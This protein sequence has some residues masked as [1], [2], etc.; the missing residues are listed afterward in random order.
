VA[1]HTAASGALAAHPSEESALLQ[2]HAVALTS[3]DR[4][5]EAITVLRH[6][7]H[8]SPLDHRAALRLGSALEAGG[9]P[10]AAITQFL[11]AVRLKN[12]VIFRPPPDSL[13]RPQSGPP[14]LAIYCDEYGQTWWEGWGPSSLGKGLGGSEEAVIFLSRWV[15]RG[16]SGRLAS[17]GGDS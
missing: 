16:A 5:D 2:S 7:V 4:V 14:V 8:L 10:E 3:L 15:G 13:K 9:N 6:V 1:C 11:A 17:R 12:R